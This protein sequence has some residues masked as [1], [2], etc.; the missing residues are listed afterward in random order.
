LHIDGTRLDAF[1]RNR[2]DALH[3]A[4]PLLTPTVT[5]APVLKNI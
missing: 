5:Q 3:H 4:L 2:S 1:E